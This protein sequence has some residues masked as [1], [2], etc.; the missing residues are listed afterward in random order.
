MIW[1]GGTVRGLVIVVVFGI[2]V[3]PN[4]PPWR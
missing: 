4:Q 1:Y 2:L 3:S